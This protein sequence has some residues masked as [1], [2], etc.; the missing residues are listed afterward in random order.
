M[1]GLRGLAAMVVVFHHFACAFFPA[2]I[3]GP[4]QPAHAVFEPLVQKTPLYLLVAGNFAV[5]IFFLISGYVLSYKFFATKRDETVVSGAV[6]RYFRLMPT[7]L[8]SVLLSY[9]ILAAGL[10][11]NLPAAAVT[12]STSWLA[13]YWNGPAH[14]FDAV[15]LGLY[16]AFINGRNI[17]VYNNAL[18]TM[19]IEFFGS[20]IVFAVLL[21]FGKLRRRWILYAVLGLL[22]WK[23]YYLALIL[24]LALC[25]FSVHEGRRERRL[26]HSGYGLAALAMGLLL[27]TLPL[28]GADQTLVGRLGSNVMAPDTAFVFFHIVGATFVM[29]ALV[30]MPK[31]RALLTLRPFQY[32]GRVSFSLYLV[33]L[34]VIASVGCYA[35]LAFLPHFGYIASAALSLAVSFAVIFA[36]A[37]LLTRYIDV[38]AI[39]LSARFYRRWFANAKTPEPK[40][41]TSANIRL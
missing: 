27:G 30:L 22:F 26:G 10:Y 32:L 37:E 9:V 21:M 7:V 40:D 33:H 31:L 14:L 24:G 3:F 38:P 15:R 2:I 16:D 11:H 20:F 4:S 18:W 29:A 39:R 12:G 23:T 5:C 25:D 36:L 13:M 28:T 41:A 19:K 6:R 17:G 34:S 1:D 8:A 35:F